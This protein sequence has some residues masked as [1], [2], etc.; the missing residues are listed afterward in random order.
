MA[1]RW[2]CRRRAARRSRRWVG[3]RRWFGPGWASTFDQRLEI[4][5]EGVLLAPATG[6]ILSFPHPGPDEVVPPEGV[7]GCCR[8]A[9]ATTGIR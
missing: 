3:W 5:E 6:A 8:P 1:V 7:R 9:T 4:D 2:G